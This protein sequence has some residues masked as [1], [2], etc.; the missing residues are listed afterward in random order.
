MTSPQDH[1]K[2]GTPYHVDRHALVMA[3]DTVVLING[4]PAVETCR[5]CGTRKSFLPYVTSVNTS[6]DVGDSASATITMSIPRYKRPEFFREGRVA[7]ERMDEVKIYFKSRFSYGDEKD[8]QPTYSP[9]FWGMVSSVSYSENS[10][11]LNITLT[12]KGILYWWEITTYVLNPSTYD[13]GNGGSTQGFNE[14]FHHMNPYAIIRALAEEFDP[15]TLAVNPSMDQATK[16][17]T[18]IAGARILPA[19]LDQEAKSVLGSW[20]NVFKG[21]RELLRMFAVTF[22]PLNEDLAGR[23]G[24]FATAESREKHQA[25]VKDS[26]KPIEADV[27]TK[28]ANL[29]SYTM[30]PNSELFQA[31]FPYNALDTSSKMETMSKN[32]LEIAREVKRSIN[33]EFF[34]DTTG[35]LVFKPPYYNLDVNVDGLATYRIE[36][37]DI[38]SWSFSESE[39]AVVTRVEVTGSRSLD[40]NHGPA[41]EVFGMYED[42]AL[43]SRYGQRVKQISAPH[44]KSPALCRLFAAAEMGYHS[45]A[46]YSGTVQIVGRPELRLGFPVYFPA[47]DTYA[48]ITGI[49]HDFTFGGSF[50]TSLTLTAFRRKY[51]SFKRDKEGKSLD[52]QANVVGEFRYVSGDSKEVDLLNAATV[53]QEAAKQKGTDVPAQKMV[54]GRWYEKKAVTPVY[55]A[56]GTT[57]DSEGKYLS[58]D[59]PLSDE[60]GYELIGPYPYGRGIALDAKGNMRLSQAA[61]A[62]FNSSR[63]K[64]LDAAKSRAATADVKLDIDGVSLSEGNQAQNV[65]SANN[66]GTAADKKIATQKTA[67]GGDTLSIRG[68][69]VAPAKPTNQKPAELAASKGQQARAANPANTPASTASTNLPTRG[70]S[71]LAD[72]NTADAHMAVRVTEQEL[73]NLH[74]ISPDSPSGNDC[75]CRTEL[76]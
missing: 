2:A 70:N 28:S 30:I 24:Q 76:A 12:C 52:G 1:F 36:D 42:P 41:M 75:S 6:L 64:Q 5:D 67:P 33:Y 35:E 11:A 32:R 43:S 13:Q 69:P 63:Q 60:F 9:A 31:V 68:Q 17:G 34:M 62:F 21:M 8:K 66:T 51:R 7:F 29:R 20:N 54:V 22:E 23:E 16:S 74:N 56:V 71:E 19:L 44:L 65:A 25:F 37:S 38:L 72:A 50:T 3:P 15:S 61:Q 53:T 4:S 49:S 40:I 45:M 57:Q 26:K 27:A 18:T 14:I 73:K 10:G 47:R 48:Y 39:D 46:Q 58:S 59:V 55:M